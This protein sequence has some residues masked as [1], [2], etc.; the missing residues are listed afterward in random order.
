MKKINIAFLIIII[1]C[2]VMLVIGASKIKNK[3]SLDFY[4]KQSDYL[5]FESNGLF[6]S[7]NY[8]KGEVIENCPAL[9]LNKSNIDEIYNDYSFKANKPGIENRLF[10]LGYCGLINHSDNNYNVS[11]NVIDDKFIQFY[12]IKNIK[13]DEEFLTNYGKKYWNSPSKLAEKI[14]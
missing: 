1:L 13:K 2:L 5:P 11:W 9:K 3:F 4:V 10:S 7:R 14:D 8:K 12:C 6:A